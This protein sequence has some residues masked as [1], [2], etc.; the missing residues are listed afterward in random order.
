VRKPPRPLKCVVPGCDGRPLVRGRCNTCDKYRRRT[1]TDRPRSLIERTAEN[2]IERNWR[3]FEQAEEDRFIRG[4]YV[5]AG[6]IV[7]SP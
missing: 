1:G 2:R 4:L 7:K 6:G 3:A 5:A